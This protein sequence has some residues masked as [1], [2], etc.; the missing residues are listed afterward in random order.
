MS[1][2]NQALAEDTDA[3]GNGSVAAAALFFGAIAAGSSIGQVSPKLGGTLSASLDATLL[4]LVFLLFFE[5][6]FGSLLTSLTNFRFLALAWGANFLLVPLI[7]F[8]IASLLLSGQPLIFIGLMIYFLAPCTDWFLGFTRMARGDTGLG[9]ALIPINLLSQLLLFPLWLWLLT[10]HT[11]ALDLGGLPILLAQWFLLPMIAAQ[12]LRFVLD[13]ILPE[14]RFDRLLVWVSQLLPFA[15]ALLI[16][17]VFVGNIGAI[18]ANLPVFAILFAAVLLFFTATFF[19]GEGLSR[20]AGL[21]YPQ[22]ALLTMTMAARNAPM[23]LAIT[24]VALPDQPLILAAIAIGMLV[25]IPHLTV[26]RQILL[27]KYAS[28]ARTV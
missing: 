6:R 23:M 25:E 5:L 27:Q 11:G 20:H 24:A 7:G 10:R 13:K 9:A 26:L 15:I 4:A 14:E 1:T 28:Q 8:G 18:S 16:F 17:Q 22:H 12:G 2:E 19:A 21:A 3:S